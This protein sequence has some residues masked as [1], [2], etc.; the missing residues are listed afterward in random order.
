[1]SWIGAAIIGSGVLGAASGAYGARQNRA[2]QEDAN[3]LNREEFEMYKPY[4]E[5]N[6]S[7]GQSALDSVLGTGAYT[8]QTYAGANP[9]QLMGNR[10]IGGAGA[11]M[12]PGAVN[13]MN[14]GQ[15][16]GQNYADM[17]AQGGEDRLGIARDYALENSQPLI[18]AAMRDASRQF[19]EVTLP[20]INRAA[21][22]SGNVNSSRAGIADAVASRGF[23][24]RYA[25]TAAGV[26]KAL[27]DQSLKTQ[28]QQF[29]DQINAN[30]G[31]QQAYLQGINAMGTAGDF[32]TGAG[33]NLQGLSQA[34]LDDLRRR[35]EE[36][37]DFALN[38]RYGFQNQM[39]G[40]TPSTTT[41]QPI[42]NSPAAA[43]FGGA[44][45]GVGMGLDIAKFL[46]GVS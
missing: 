9:Y 22:G 41:V 12:A 14:T 15:G 26:N 23:Q 25:D 24:D 4:V 7:G 45:Q 18:D 6:L 27:M 31:V 38:Q 46:E 16:F 33:G 37:R 20:G 40:N 1:M 13:L 21:S 19:S 43:G 32:M 34:Q 42:T 30:R 35:F 5:G 8:G 44:M 29:S 11:Y 39:L 36:Q 10:F 17:F 3:R 28:A 2:A